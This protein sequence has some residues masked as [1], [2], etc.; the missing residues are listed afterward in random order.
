MSTTDPVD[1]NG[2]KRMTLIESLKEIEKYGWYWGAISAKEAALLLADEPIGTFLVRNSRSKEYFMSLTYNTP[3]GIY[4]SRVAWHQGYFCLGGPATIMKARSF[5][6]LINDILASANDPIH[7]IVMF[8]TLERSDTETVHLQ[9]TL[10]RFDFL[11]S[12]KYLCRCV[13]RQNTTTMSL[14][15]L[16]VP[17]SIKEYLASPKYLLVHY[18]EVETTERVNRGDKLAMLTAMKRR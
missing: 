16:P 18:S 9:R 5:V 11:P 4:H 12:L 17:K 13:I 3:T 14:C 1:D 7:N 15:S 10:D 6:N 2:E 8:P